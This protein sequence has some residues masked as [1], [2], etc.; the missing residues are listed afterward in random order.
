MKTKKDKSFIKSRRFNII[1]SLVLAIGIWVIVAMYI[2]PEKTRVIEKVPVDFTYN[3]PS[4]TGQNL[5]IIDKPNV[6]VNINVEGDGYIIDALRPE[7]F[8]VYPSYTQVKGAGKY[9]L[10][11]NAKPV[12]GLTFKVVSISPDFVSVQFDKVVSKKF[13]VTVIASGIET[14]AG[15]FMDVPVSAPTEITLTGPEAQVNSVAKVVANV[16]MSEKRKE[17][18]ITNAALELQD[19]DGNVI[20]DSNI[21]MDAEQIEARIPILEEREIPIKVGF[22]GAP[23]GFDTSSLKMELSNEIIH[24]AGQTKLWDT[25]TELDAGYVDLTKFTM[26]GEYT[27][28]ITL[29]DG[30]VN[31]DKLLSVTATFDTSKIATKVVAVS[32][33]RVS[34]TMPAGLSLTLPDNA[35]VKNVVLAGP[36]EVLDEITPQSVVAQMNAQDVAL[37]NA[38]QNV[39]VQI[40]IPSSSQVFVI[41]S[42]TV[43]C[44]TQVA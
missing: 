28:P 16:T 2:D 26:D 31:M 42:Y 33:I 20:T 17:S 15:Y 21:T 9:E 36:A 3:S 30:F 8:T 43:L 37:T 38:K 7:D 44:D 18:V 4:Y 14:E 24:V 27:F 10:M 1:L 34:G 12:S 6:Y 40:I 35:K 11:L 5:D 29:P 25:F 19:K 22:I 39:P 23:I 32:D 41:G 13:P